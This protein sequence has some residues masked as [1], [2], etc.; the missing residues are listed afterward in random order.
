MVLSARHENYKD[1]LVLLINVLAE[2]M[3]I[4]LGSFGS[5]TLRREDLARGFE[6]DA[7]FYIQHEAQVRG[8]EQL[9]LRVDPPPDL[10]LE[11]DIISPSLDKLPLYAAMGVAEVWRYDG[12]NLNFYWLQAN[13]DQAQPESR[14]LPGLTSQVVAHFL[15]ESQSLKRTVWL[16]RVREWARNNFGVK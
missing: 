8:K 7:C 6:P 16:R 4:D 3:G 2:E 5:T 14:A 15:A 11:I 13:A 1:M 9:D 10:V 12:Q